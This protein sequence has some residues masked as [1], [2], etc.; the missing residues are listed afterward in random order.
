MGTL[1]Y[2]KGCL[3][4][5]VALAII[6]VV[7]DYSITKAALEAKKAEVLLLSEKMKEQ[8]V[9]IKALKVDIDKYKKQKPKI[10]EKIVT[11][12]KNITLKDN[13]CESYMKAI[14]EAN[15]IFIEEISK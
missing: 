6:Y 4:A 8:N 1:T 10:V 11:K 9:A 3:I 14:N 15:H 7:W 12:Y 5:I 2:V 13:S